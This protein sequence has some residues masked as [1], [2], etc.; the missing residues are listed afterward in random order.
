[1][2]MKPDISLDIIQEV[3]NAH[4]PIIRRIDTGSSS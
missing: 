2:M 1:M 3:P 4:K